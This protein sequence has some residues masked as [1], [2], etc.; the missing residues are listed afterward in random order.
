MVKI[1]CNL[2]YL[3]DPGFRNINRLFVLSIIPQ[4]INFTGKLEKDDGSTMFFIAEKQ[5]KTI[6]NFFFRFINCNRII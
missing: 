4:Q 5:E 1:L 6:V 3:V 2:D